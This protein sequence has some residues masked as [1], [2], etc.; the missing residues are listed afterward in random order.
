MPIGRGAGAENG[1]PRG[2]R[3]QLLRGGVAG[4]LVRAGSVLAGV[5]ASVALAR[6]LGPEKFGIYAFVLSLITLLGLPVKMGLPTLIVRETARAD[7]AADG[8]LMLGIWRWSDRAMA[9]MA[10]AVLALSGAYVWLVAGLE[11]P[12]MIA[13]LCAL[14]LVPLIGLAEAR[15]A[16]IRGLRRVALGTAPDKILRPLLLAGAVAAVGWVSA[17]PPSAAQVY[18]IHCGVAI[19]TVGVANAIATRIRPQHP[20]SKTPRTIPRAWIAAILPLSALAGLQ[21]IS[22]N[23]DILMLGTLASDTEAGLYRVALSGAN[24][25]LFGLTTINLVLQPYFAQSCS[26]GD[27][28]Q[29][30]RLAAAGARFSLLLSLPFLAV[31]WFGGTWLLSL[32]YGEAYA[33]AFWA[34]IL[35]CLGQTVNAF[36][37][38]VGNLLT[39]SGREWIA[40]S[41]LVLSTLVNVGLNWLLI[42]RYGIEGAAFATGLSIAAWNIA[43]WYAT[44]VTLRIDSSP[45]GLRRSPPATLIQTREK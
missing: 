42:P 16:A 1:S 19:I 35:L 44:W 9:L 34:L 30:Q 21:M 3:A 38:S 27:H 8:A 22:H 13:L 45:L 18:L 6:V 28:R 10:A 32:I 26:E 29:L 24:I 37:G 15:G 2:L 11:S 17:V 12:R 4:L 23:T 31:F 40:V 36:F 39:M 14:P 5:I 41:G 43:L 33:G 7:Q 25:A 20:G